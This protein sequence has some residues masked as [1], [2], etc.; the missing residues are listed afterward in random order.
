MSG[1]RKVLISGA[2]IKTKKID[3]QESDTVQ[4]V[5]NRAEVT[6]RSGQTATLGKTRVTDPAKTP[7]SPGD[8]IVIAGKPGNGC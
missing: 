8:T 2:G 1:N 7:V 5:L 3:W 6:L 4:T